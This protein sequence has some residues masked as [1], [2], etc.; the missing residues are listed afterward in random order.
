[1]TVVGS[2]AEYGDHVYFVG[3][4]QV[5]EE[6]T[7][8]EVEVFAFRDELKASPGL[9]ALRQK[10]PNPHIMWLRGQY[11]EAD[12]ANANGDM[13]SAGDL[14][15]ASLTPMFA[16]CTVMHDFT[17]SVGLIADATLLTPNKDGVPRA[18]IDTTLAIWAHRYPQVAEE[19]RINSQQGTL[20]QSMECLSA[21]YSCSSCGMVYQ[22][23]P[24][25]AEKAQWCDCLQGKTAERGNRMLRNTTFS[26]V[27]LIFGTRGARPAFKDA[28]LEVAELAA[29][30]QELHQAI[31]PRETVGQ[32]SVDQAEYEATV[33]KAAK[34]DGLTTQVRDLTA[35][36]EELTTKVAELEPVAL[37][38]P[39]LE[40]VAA[41][42]PDLETRVEEAEAEK[43]KAEEEAK[44][45]KARADAA[46]E[47]TNK[48]TLRDERIA[49]LGEGFKN[50]LEKAPTTKAR[51]H[52]QAASLSEE[53][54]KARLDELKETLGVDPEAPASAEDLTR[55]GLFTEEQVARAGLTQAVDTPVTSV[56]DA[57]RRKSA[58]G[59]LTRAFGKPQKTS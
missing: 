52:E 12:N 40:T 21:S 50:R 48:Q 7:P 24:H 54:W 10:A 20:A 41:K 34:L 49:G 47:E 1:M 17:S 13:W 27:G 23:Q 57:A 44:A 35:R 36:N 28:K 11:V 30:H 22:R 6:P 39:E 31:T 46:E 33:A 29:A 8:D 18:R 53:E 9:E 14:A 5:I 55:V 58:V 4:V 56:S 19:I 51:L 59:G 3:P 45:E 15:I 32:I 26:G 43:I 2:I 16:P 38:V 25:M 37:K 42:V